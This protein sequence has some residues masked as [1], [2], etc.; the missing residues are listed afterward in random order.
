MYVYNIV[1][2]HNIILYSVAEHLCT[3]SCPMCRYEYRVCPFHNVTQKEEGARWGR[4][5]GVLGFVV[6]VT[7][8]Q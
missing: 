4:Y 6:V 3:V 1:M 2:D 5:H 8:S 7:R